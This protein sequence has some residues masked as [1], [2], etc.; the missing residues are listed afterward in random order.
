MKTHGFEVVELEPHI[1]DGGVFVHFKY[2]A[3]EQGE[4]LETIEKSVREEAEK[5]GGIPSWTGLTKRGDVWLVKGTPWREV[6]ACTI[7]GPLTRFNWERRIY[8]DTHPRL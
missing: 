3:G 7:A 1:K 2:N 8:T 6:R 4:A 5:Q